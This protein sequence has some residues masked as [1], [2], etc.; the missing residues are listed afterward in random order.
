MLKSESSGMDF[1]RPLHPE[2]Y[3]SNKANRRHWSSSESRGLLVIPVP[4]TELMW[5]E[6]EAMGQAFPGGVLS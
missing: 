2:A 1:I 5:K 4:Q 3:N 6:V